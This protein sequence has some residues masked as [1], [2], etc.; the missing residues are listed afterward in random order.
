[1]ASSLFVFSHCSLVDYISIESMSWTYPQLPHT[2]RCAQGTIDRVRSIIRG[3][4]RSSIKTEA[5]LL[6]WSFFHDRRTR[7][8][9]RA[10]VTPI[11][12]SIIYRSTIPHPEFTGLESS[13]TRFLNSPQRI[14][15]RSHSPRNHEEGALET[16][17]EEERGCDG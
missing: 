1:M 2:Y 9:L 11:W 3:L 16:D 14:S 5:D 12:L 13:S 15:R 17:S 7:S 4:V 8:I 6:V 10:L